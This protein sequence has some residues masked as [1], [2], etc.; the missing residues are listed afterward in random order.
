VHL[1]GSSSRIEIQIPFNPA[2]GAPTRLF[3]DDGSALD[4]SKLETETLAESDQY[5]LQGDAFSRVVR[6]EITLPY[7]VADAVRN[8][9][10]IDAL[11][12]SEQSGRWEPV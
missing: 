7:G 5:M 12:R 3:I 4:G 1:H 6:G 11:F 2:Q 10:V 8:M 9:K